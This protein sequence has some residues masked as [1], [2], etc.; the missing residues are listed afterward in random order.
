MA[1][2]FPPARNRAGQIVTGESMIPGTLRGLAN[3]LAGGGRGSV[4]ATLGAPA[5]ILN[6]LRVK[7]MGGSDLPYGS[8]Y[9][10]N[11]LPMAPTTQEG[12]VA[13]S[14]G[15]FIPTPAQT[16]TAPL[17]AA[18]PFLKRGVREAA[19]YAGRQAVNL[20]EKY[21]VSPTMNV[22]KP[23]GGNWISGSVERSIE[24]LKTKSIVGQTP[25]ERI[26]LH[27]A[28]LNDQSFNADQRDRINYLLEQ[29]RK[30]AAT[31]NW[32][33]NKL[34]KYI[35]NE[36][37]T[38]EDPIRAL[39]ER[40]VLHVDPN[41]LNFRPDAYGRYPKSGQEFL[42]ESDAA[43]QW[44]G[45]S[46]NVLSTSRAGEVTRNNDLRNYVY[47]KDLIAENPWLLKVPPETKVYNPIE[48]E[49]LANDL[50]F[51]HLMD[52]LR[53]AM[54]PASGLPQH[55]QID[56]SKLDKVTVPQAVQRVHDINEWRAAQK[57]EADA[58]KARNPAT[59]VHKDYE[60]QPYHWVELKQPEANV[61]EGSTWE[62]Y[63]GMQRLFGP[64][65]ESLS[66]GATQ[67][68][69]IKLL[70]RQER[71]KM[72]EDALKYE[73]DTMGH[74]VGGY[75]PDVS[76]GRSRIFSLRDKKTGQPHVTIETKPTPQRDLNMSSGQYDKLL[77]D[78]SAAVQRGEVD[79]NKLDPKS[80]Y[81]SQGEKAPPLIK[82]IKGKANRAPNE[83][84][85]PYVQDFV[86]SQP[87]SDVGDLSNVGLYSARDVAN[88]TPQKFHMS[89]VDRSKALSNA[90]TAGELPDY[91]TREEYEDLLK[92]HA[93]EGDWWWRNKNKAEGF[94]KGGAVE[95]NPDHVE[96]LAQGLRDLHSQ[97]GLAPHGL[98]HAG[99][100][101][102]GLGYFGAIP[103]AEGMST[104]ISSE[105]D[106]GE[107]PLL[108]PGLTGAEIRHLVSG[109]EPTE[110]IYRKAEEH[111]AKRRESG[112]S[113]FS[114]ADELR[115]P[116][117]EKFAEGGAV[118]YNPSRIDALVSK[119][120]E[121]V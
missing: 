28:L 43:K 2:Y 87:W 24:P 104:E 1:D 42:A 64:Q 63:N 121:E 47:D 52:E 29:T 113:T 93:P 14:L 92:K 50:G 30:E 7:Q 79:P 35:K 76:E 90:K 119:L 78:Y 45:V 80:W 66:I 26:P 108:V 46:D 75:C 96:N 48:P 31:D 49:G 117:P 84:Y 21:G 51:D 62:E 118:E 67:D 13:Q 15:E 111:A 27:E 95:Y 37:G 68:E 16:V 85:V 4:A 107:Y 6:L 70:N 44:E 36:M 60:D 112:K 116:I 25:A 77:S 3:I 101:A 56:A 18:A 71:I 53:N 33:E 94:A 55:L 39:A 99:D 12:R 20:M 103:A 69:A 61:P 59:Y 81:L 58:Q 57:A 40:N 22:I 23:K 17:R 105:D 34:G 54:N 82:Q 114:Q 19:P 100:S 88:F 115:Y 98:R 11:N 110:S 102:K 89:P 97:E 5:D 73:G 106:Q 72:L 120:R 8:E 83:E 74:C 38:P 65:G 41:N 10:L 86:R 109:G 32:V 9:F 91:V